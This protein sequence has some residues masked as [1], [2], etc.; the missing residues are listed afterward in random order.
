MTAPLISPYGAWPSPITA[1]M[2]AAGGVGLSQLR[3]DGP[4]FYFLESRPLEG[5]RMVLLR[6]GA[7]GRLEELTPAPFN[8]RT[9][10][11]EYGGGSYVADAGEVYFSHFADQ[12]LYRLTPGRPPLA[13]TSPAACRYADAV[14]D[15]PRRRLLCVRE[16]HRGGRREPENAIVALPFADATDGGGEPL[17]RGHDFCSHPRLSPDG[18]RLCWLAWDHPNMPWDGT[19]LWV[20]ALAGDGRPRDPVRVAGG[21]GESVGQPQWAGDGSLL[22]VS[23]RSG[24]YNLY[25]WDG[26]TCQALCPRAAEFSGPQWG[27]GVATWDFASPQLLACVASHDG[28]DEVLLLDLVSGRVEPLP[29]PYTSVGELR[30]GAGR[31]LFT[32]A[33]A[34]CATELVSYDLGARQA[35]VVRRSQSLALPTDCLARPQAR[36][37]PTAGGLTAHAIY[38]PPTNPRCAAPAGDLPPLL[39]K[40]HGGPTAAA[41]TALNLKLQY[42]TSRGFAVCDVN[43]GGSSGYGRA[44]RQRLAGQWGV[45]DVADCAAAARDLAAH[46]LVDSRRLLISGGSAGGYTTLCA[47]T[48]TDVFR[49]GASYYGV[50]DL[51]TLARDTHKFESRYLDRLVGP[52]P[53]RRDLYEARSP[54]AHVERLACPVIFLQGLE[55]CIVPPNQAEL[56]VAALQRKGLPVAY[57]TFAGEQHGFRRAE[58]IARALE[59][60]R[61][62]YARVLGLP[63]A[64]PMAPVP[65]M[66][67]AGPGA[68]AG[69]AEGE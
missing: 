43:Y 47:L 20:A 55:D 44:Y 2:T 46:G 1:A 40:S 30:A 31:L 4:D 8:V 32:A 12:R 57:L 69:R 65:I 11:H 26:V 24:W 51:A 58:N 13:F 5:G 25:R 28:T 14:L 10:V 38:Y 50:S 19:E 21:A 33:A 16:D 17:V 49:A 66:N 18:R 27:L 36:S 42:W 23:D 22:F 62:F 59:A 6:G 35:T 48:F 41:S 61:Y 54:L 9:R 37:F 67:L 68:A 56:M 60:E 34:D 15:R 53:A 7:D 63:L 39:I 29:L 64:E 3:L 52:Y 45:V